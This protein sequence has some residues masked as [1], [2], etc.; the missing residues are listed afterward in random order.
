LDFH[1]IL[2]ITFN[3]QETTANRFEEPDQGCIRLSVKERGAGNMHEICTWITENYALSSADRCIPP[4][5]DAALALL[6][7]ATK[8][9]PCQ[10]ILQHVI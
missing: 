8:I 2:F 4:E 6:R 3:Q 7:R 5:T 10:F 9:S 1:F